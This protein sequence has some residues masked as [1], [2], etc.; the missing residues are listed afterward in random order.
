MTKVDAHMRREHETIRN[1]VGFYNFTHQLLEVTG[2]E[3]GKFL[4]RIFVN[5]IEDCEVGMAKYTTMLNED[6]EITDDV[7]VFR[8]EEEKF[9]VST[10][11]IQE[12]IDWFD[13]H[14][15]NYDVSYEEITEDV[16][17]YAVQGPKSREFLN[18]ILRDDISDIRYQGIKDN[19]IEDIEVK[20]ARAGFTGELGYEIYVVPACNAFMEEKLCETGH[21]FEVDM[22][23]SD[24][25]L[26]SLP[27]EK[28]YVLMSDL[29]GIN[30]IEAGFGWSVDWDTDFIGKDVLTKVKE[31][32]PKRSLLGFTVQDD[33]A[34]IE[35]GDVIK[36]DGKEVGKVT[37]FTY[38]FTVEKG[39]GFALVENDLAEIGD[40]VLIN[41]YEGELTERM[42][43]D[44][45]NKKVRG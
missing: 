33:E 35:A 18:T 15:E 30:P 32:G 36:K 8:L 24:A 11:F 37:T 12:M 42:F 14:K 20:V 16:S 43:Y 10:L 17:M 1:H 7:I 44:P 29:E 2:P 45:E 26:S 21:E 41:D 40:K 38:G 9:W 13:S 3:A 22:I 6:G 28:G 23:T 39:I 19:M 25:V 4:D 34:E 5:S 27:R 31:E